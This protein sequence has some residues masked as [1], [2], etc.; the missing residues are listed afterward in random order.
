M[1]VMLAAARGRGFRHPPAAKQDIAAIRSEMDSRFA[2]S[3][4]EMAR[5]CKTLY[6]NIRVMAARPVSLTVALVKLIP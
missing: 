4:V 3:Q 5:G 2:A 1:S 6:R